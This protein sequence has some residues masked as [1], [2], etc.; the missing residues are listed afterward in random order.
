MK[1]PKEKIAAAIKNNRLAI[2]ASVAAQTALM[3]VSPAMAAEGDVSTLGQ[4]ISSALSEG[5]NAAVTD[6]VGY[7]TAI[8]PLGLTVFGAIWGTKKAMGFFRTTAGR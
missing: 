2:G 3:A 4:K 7:V 5:L 6:F 8:L 1:F